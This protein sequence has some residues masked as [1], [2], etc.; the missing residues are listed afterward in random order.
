MGENKWSW[1]SYDYEESK[2]SRI[3]STHKMVWWMFVDVRQPNLVWNV[4]MQVDSKTRYG[5]RLGG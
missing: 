1:F 3:V 4:K 2:T 5:S